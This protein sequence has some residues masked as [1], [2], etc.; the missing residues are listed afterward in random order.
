MKIKYLFSDI[1]LACT[2]LFLADLK[3]NAKIGLLRLS[4]IN[5]GQFCRPIFEVFQANILALRNQDIRILFSLRSIHFIALFFPTILKPLSSLIRL[6]WFSHG[7]KKE[8]TLKA[9]GL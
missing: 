3:E 4:L 6:T 1:G 7:S 8:C 2:K 9:N 5:T